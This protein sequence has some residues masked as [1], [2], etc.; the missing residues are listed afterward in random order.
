MFLEGTRH[1]L[2]N[3]YVVLLHD[4]FLTAQEPQCSTDSEKMMMKI[5]YVRRTL[6]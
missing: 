5:H 3:L 2:F 6:H 1:T 4:L